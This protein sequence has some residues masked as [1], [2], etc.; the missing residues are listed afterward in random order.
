MRDRL[1][2]ADDIKAYCR[3]IG[4]DLVGITNA[5]PFN[6]FKSNVER[7][8][9]NGWIDTFTKE[10]EQAFQHYE[11][12]TDPKSSLP[13]AR[14]IIVIGVSY[15][16]SK[17]PKGD[18]NVGPKGTLGR[19]YWYDFHPHLEDRRRLVVEYLQR[20]GALVAEKSLVPIK[21]AAMR[22]GVGVYGKNTIIQNEEFGS[23]V[24]FSAIVTDLDLALDEEWEPR[25][26][27]CQRCIRLCP[28][29]AI[30]EPYVLNQSRCLNHVLA[31]PEPIPLALR[32]SVGMRINGCDVCQEV[33]PRNEVVTPTD[34]S[35]GNSW[36]TWS[37]TPDLLQIL[38]MDEVDFKDHFSRLDWYVPRL[39]FLRRNAVVALGNS[40][41]VSVVGKLESLLN[42]K[43]PQVRGHAS[44]ALARL[45]SGRS[46]ELL[47]NQME[48]EHDHYVR[49]E[50]EDALQSL[51]TEN[52][53]PI[54]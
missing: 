37:P 50:M 17:P 34:R 11:L 14:S 40:G 13:S 30:A 8:I 5:E 26:G 16:K 2:T 48:A 32:E 44:W 41:D 19:P 31:S 35:F 23:W 15:L 52:E 12:W 10:H 39:E 46:I 6:K 53:V 45:R 36:G 29:K 9:R 51:M 1:L 22:A 27:A 28:S 18:E 42:D 54:H 4:L 47:K 33:C 7:S 20:D 43:E 49:K 24:L 38:D 21:A 25:C 3:S